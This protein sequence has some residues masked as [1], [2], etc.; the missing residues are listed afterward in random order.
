MTYV[1]VVKRSAKQGL[2][3]EIN[4]ILVEQLEKEGAKL[5]DIKLSG[6]SNDDSDRYVALLIFETKRT[7]AEF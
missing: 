3:D 4:S 5:V 6:A 1:K 2:E 7:V